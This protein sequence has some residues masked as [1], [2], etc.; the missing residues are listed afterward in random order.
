MPMSRRGPLTSSPPTVIR[1]EVG[2]MSPPINFNKVDLPQP[3]GPTKDTNCPGEMLK[4][5]SCNASTATVLR[6]VRNTF[7]TFSSSIASVRAPAL[8]CLCRDAVPSGRSHAGLC[9]VGAGIVIYYL[10]PRRTLGKNTVDEDIISGVIPQPGGARHA[11][12]A[13][14]RLR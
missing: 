14:F 4:L 10:F 7:P 6:R 5:T 13:R 8:L 1:P 11:P 9:V 12:E 3:L 2:S